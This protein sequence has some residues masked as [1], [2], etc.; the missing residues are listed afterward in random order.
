MVAANGTEAMGA[1]SFLEGDGSPCV[2]IVDLGLPDERGVVDPDAGFGVIQAFANDA[3]AVPVIV[4]SIRN[5]R[6]GYERCRGCDTV[7]HFV[8]KPWNSAQLKHNVESC[9]AGRRPESTPRLTGHV[10]GVHA[11]A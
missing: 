8:T 11:S 6:D 2:A 5:D 4:L 9:L 1:I 7:W 3:P 10:E